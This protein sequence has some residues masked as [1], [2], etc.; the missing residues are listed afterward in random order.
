MGS[1]LITDDVL[2][3]ILSRSLHTLTYGEIR[4]A[5]AEILENHVDEGIS[6]LN[7]AKAHLLISLDYIKPHKQEDNKKIIG[8]IESLS[9][10][11]KQ[12]E[13]YMEKLEMLSLNS[14]KLS[15]G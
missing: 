2:K 9:N 6:C 1:D 12:N 5:R 3:V 13:N 11:L 14:K 8:L 7:R 15:I 4:L 10:S